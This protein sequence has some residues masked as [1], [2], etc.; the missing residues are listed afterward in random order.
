M[1]ND[2]FNIIDDRIEPQPWTQY[3]TL[4]TSQVGPSVSRSYD[5]SGGGDKNDLAHTV[6]VAWTNNTPV[7][8]WVYGM[9]TRGGATVTLQ[10][11]SRG[12]LATL[13]GQEIQ[14]DATP[15]ETWDMYEA[16]RFGGGMDIGKGGILALGSGFG[17]HEVRQNSQTAPLMPHKIGWNVVQPGET[18]FARVQVIFKT[19]F[20]ENTTIDGGDQNTESLFISGE[21]RIDLYGIPAVIEPA[22]RPN[23]TVV[24][25]EHSTNY[26][27]STDVDVPPN[28]QA[29]DILIAV[30]AN[31][32][33]LISDLN[34]EQEGWVLQHTRDAGWENSHL[35]VWTRIATA[36]E[37]DSYT[38]SNGLLAEALTHLIALRDADPDW[39]NGW[40]FASTLRKAW[41]MADDGHIA[42]SIDR[43]GQLLLCVSYLPHALWQ[44]DVLQTPPDGM[45][46]IGDVSADTSSMAVAVLADPPRPT[47]ERMFV[48]SE[49]PEWSGRG[50]ALSI[51]V[52]GSQVI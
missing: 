28:V 5:T 8:T 52:P 14:A 35:K 27:F 39:T 36:D 11:R 50:I 33:G 10:S 45:T 21:T 9:V 47:R 19:E 30:H 49:G 7:S 12:Y 29:G 15:P 1:S 43:R 31:N 17:V 40:Q 18:F 2:H 46:E 4:A 41:W 16:S 51:L 24:G 34:P 32:F 44:D 25:V 48:P 26:T 3:R 23:P 37:P 38:F 6:D 42:P 22:P 20:W 13:H